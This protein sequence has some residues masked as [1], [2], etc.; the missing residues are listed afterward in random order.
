MK[1]TLLTGLALVVVLIAGAFLVLPTAVQADDQ[2]DA[3]LAKL[4]R[5][6]AGTQGK[7]AAAIKKAESK[8]IPFGA[9]IEVEDGRTVYEVFVYVE[10]DEAKVLEVEIDA[11]TGEILEVE[12][13]DDDDDEHEDG[14]DDDDEEED[15]DE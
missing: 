8:G 14:D 9:K 3:G 4:G 13:A 6:V 12:D 1:Y 11:A 10:G 5:A 2:A 15:D 7:L